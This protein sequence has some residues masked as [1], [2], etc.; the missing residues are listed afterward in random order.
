MKS[1][2]E[3]PCDGTEGRVFASSRPGAYE[4]LFV[5][6]RGKGRKMKEY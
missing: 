4:L 3:A 5:N 1:E 2:R 6:V